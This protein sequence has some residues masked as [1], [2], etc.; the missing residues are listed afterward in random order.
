M[1]FL[2]Y[3][4]LLPGAPGSAPFSASL[5]GE[6]KSFLGKSV[7]KTYM[8]GVAYAMEPPRGA[9]DPESYL[10]GQI[11]R[12]IPAYGFLKE[13]PEY[14]TQI[15]SQNT[16]EMILAKEAR[17]ENQVDPETG[18]LIP[19]GGGAGD[20]PSQSGG[21]NPAADGATSGNGN[22]SSAAGNNAV[23]NP[24]AAPAN[25]AAGNNTAP[26]DPAAATPATGAAV[27]A[28]AAAP[29]SLEKLN[30]FD[31]LISHFYV[32]DNTTTIN[33]SELVASELMAKDMRL[34]ADNSAPQILIYHTHSQEGYADSTPGDDNTTIM[35]VGERL[36]TL[37]RNSGFNVIHHQGQYDLGG[38]DYAYANAAP[39]IE[40]ILAAN[41]GIEVVID[42]HRDGVNENVR[43]ATEVNGKPT[44]KIMFFNGL[45][46]TT[47]NG[48]I[49]Y[50]KN[51]Y[52][53]DNLAFSLQLQMKA[54]Q[55][56]PDFTRNIYLKGYRYNMHFRPKCILVEVGAQTNTVEEAMNAMEPLAD[57][58]SKVLKGN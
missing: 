52:I 43:L 11:M 33:S 45:S 44:A 41:P 25:P 35:G 23:S 36:A 4:F 38:R 15:E 28:P 37:L 57:I 40:A 39:D 32:V 56:Y 22:A 24:D 19:G 1:C 26:T 47:K 58:L 12:L 42:V 30:D 13:Y 34:A 17:D 16:Y 55:Y 54:A 50:L 31:Y 49:D 3:G 6:A 10:A 14:S 20:L 51:P 27:P 29:F 48:D 7:L 5:L 46:R 53:Q 18:Q 21:A 9:F 8:P 2:L